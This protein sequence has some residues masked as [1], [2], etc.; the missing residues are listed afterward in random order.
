MS[1]IQ[2]YDYHTHINK[3]SFRTNGDDINHSQRTENVS[4]SEE[5]R[6]SKSIL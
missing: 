3:M 4:F 1:E 6:V 2:H 5:S